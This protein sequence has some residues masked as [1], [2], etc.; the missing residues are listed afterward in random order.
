MPQA[1]RYGLLRRALLPGVRTAIEMKLLMIIAIAAGV[2][3][4]GLITAVESMSGQRPCA[5][6]EHAGCIAARK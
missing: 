3:M 6:R 1:Q 2:V 4:I 5:D